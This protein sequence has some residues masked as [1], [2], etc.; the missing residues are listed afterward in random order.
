ME[1][2]KVVS[3]GEKSGEGVHDTLVSN[4]S[5]YISLV[6]LARGGVLVPRGSDNQRACVTKRDLLLFIM[7]R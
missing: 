6:D 2:G 4:T 1:W 5:R 3:K 7:N